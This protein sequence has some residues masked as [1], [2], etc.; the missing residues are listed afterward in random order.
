MI[1]TYGELKQS[2]IRWIDRKDLASVIDDICML[3]IR[4]VYR[5]VRCPANERLA[6]YNPAY[7]RL[8]QDAA[9]AR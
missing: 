1:Q 4:R 5:D 9:T 2:V 7:N 3:G 6:G 8:A